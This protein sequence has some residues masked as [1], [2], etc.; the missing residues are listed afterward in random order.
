MK[1]INSKFT[2]DL[3]LTESDF[4]AVLEI[5]NKNIARDD[6]RDIEYYKSASVG[7]VL[8]AK[9]G[10]KVIG[11]IKQSRPGKVINEIGEEYL[12]LENIKVVKNDIGYI[13]WLAVDKKYQKR[14]IGRLLIDN[15]MKYQ[16][17]WGSKAV[18]VHSW[19]GSPGSASQKLFEKTGFK[20]LKMHLSPW[21]EYSEKAGPKSYWC[22]VCGNPCVCDEL[23]MIKYI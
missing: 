3:P 20:P 5:V 6:K 18:A 17:E 13:S 8:V 4:S 14:K 1:D 22:V 2:I 9:D 16:K 23:E 7:E 10:Q 15:A 19:Q 12:D 21:K 11:A